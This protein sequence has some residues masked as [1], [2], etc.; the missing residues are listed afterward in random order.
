MVRGPARAARLGLRLLGLAL[1]TV[2]LAGGCSSEVDITPPKPGATSDR[3]ASAQATV[4]LLQ[5][6]LTGRSDAPVSSL[7]APSAT[8][9][10]EGIRHNVRAMGVADL[11]MRYLDETTMPSAS[12]SG[13]NSDAWTASVDLSYRLRGFDRDAA[14]METAVVLEQGQG[15]G[16]ARIVRFGDEDDR[17]PLWLQGRLTVRRTQRSLVAVAGQLGRYPRL[18]QRAVRQVGRELRFWH[19]RIVVEVPRTRPQ[20]DTALLA[21]PGQ[22]DNIAAVTTTADGSLAPG[23]PVRVFVN[24]EVFGRLRT[25]GAQVVLTH[26]ATHAATG[27]PFATMPTWLLEGFADFVALDGSGI[28]VSRAAGQIL[29]RVRKQGAPRRL[30]TSAD[31]DPTANGLGATYEEAWLACRFLAE[32]HGRAALLHF[33]RKVNSG[34]STQEAFRSV[35]GTTQGAFV[36]AW[37]ADVERLARVTG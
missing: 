13:T 37:R 2:L 14:H 11:S 16:R 26:E 36:S 27:A 20:L 35:L 9:L 23:A 33:Y 24:P 25:Q 6:W 1:V 7:A 32:Q 15:Q 34:S 18:V 3:G 4:E 22:Y 19:G 29:G 17:T 31:L 8:R 10:L 5:R 28:P 12:A 21:S 30:P